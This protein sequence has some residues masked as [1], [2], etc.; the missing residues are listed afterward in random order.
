MW[1]VRLG[2]G[3]RAI[4]LSQ[5]HFVEDGEETTDGEDGDDAEQMGD[6]DSS[7]IKVKRK[8]VKDKGKP[9]KNEKGGEADAKQ[10]IPDATAK[11]NGILMKP[12]NT[13]QSMKVSEPRASKEWLS[14]L[15][16][17]SNTVEL[18]AGEVGETWKILLERQAV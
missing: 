12:M 2:V 14:E 15:V 17:G 1:C 10:V 13:Q 6:E 3:E 7:Q 9:T 16:T 5:L 4:R 18:R 8:G 11:L